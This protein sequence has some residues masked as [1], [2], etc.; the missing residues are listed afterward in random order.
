MVLGV[1]GLSV[2]DALG[3]RV[4][5][6]HSV[7]QMLA[8]RSTVAIGL[9]IV[10]LAFLG[11][12]RALRTRQP[13]GHALRSAC[14]LVAFVCFYAALR[15]LTLADA[16]AIAFGS[17]FLVT[18]LGRFVLKE[19]V[20]PRRWTA[21][22]VGFLGM[23]VIVRPTGAGFNPA[24]LL[25]VVSGMAYALMMVLA[26]WMTRPARPF[27]S[28]HA[29]VFYMLA[30]QAAV[31]WIVALGAWRTPDAGAL[32][33]MAAM[34]VFGILGNYGLAQAFRSAPVATVAPFEYTGLIWAV[35]LGAVMF[36]DVPPP[37]FW[38]GAAVIVGAGLYTVRAEVG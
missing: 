8:I 2:M 12:L 38:A 7:F 24:A 26:R 17:P 4:A 21:I 5:A 35:G 30:G 20:G 16:V 19:P 36:G 28:T 27:E 15:H 22:V 37:S 13:I 1:A 10:L 9:L 29:F 25:V 6:H 33:E 18:A 11:D 14:G 3:K 32:T 31:G 34:A 23:L